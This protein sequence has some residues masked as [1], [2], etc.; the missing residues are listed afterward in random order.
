MTLPDNVRSRTRPAHVDRGRGDGGDPGPPLTAA[1][2]DDCDTRVVL[3]TPVR[4]LV[5]QYSARTGR[6]SAEIPTIYPIAIILG[7]RDSGCREWLLA[8][9]EHGGLGPDPP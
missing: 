3:G 6:S 2:A 9:K 5:A 4:A 7:V 1:T 8:G